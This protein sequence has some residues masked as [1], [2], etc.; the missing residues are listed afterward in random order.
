M[1][2]N[3]NQ[4]RLAGVNQPSKTE[5]YLWIPSWT[6]VRA[7]QKTVVGEKF[8]FP[9]TAGKN[10]LWVTMLS[11][12]CSHQQDAF[13][14]GQSREEGI[15][16]MSSRGYECSKSK[17]DITH[18]AGLYGVSWHTVLTKRSS[19]CEAESLILGI[20]WSTGYHPFPSAYQTWSYNPY[21]LFPSAYQTWS[22][23]FR[24]RLVSQDDWAASSAVIKPPNKMEEGNLWA[25]H[26]HPSHWQ[27]FPFPQQSWG[28]S[29]V[30]PS[31]PH[32]SPSLSVFQAA[33][34]FSLVRHEQLPMNRDCFF[35]N[36]MS[37]NCFFINT[38]YP[39]I[40]C[41]FPQTVC[42]LKCLL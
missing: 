32:T 24:N 30:A 35:I 41:F 25:A 7:V 28:V 19:E 18:A 12:L 16:G 22:S 37:R 36:T 6:H 21:N 9:V 1:E 33:E 23:C 26:C 34:L 17:K 2:R 39:E 20:F 3:K 4:C 40:L 31:A 42:L 29:V 8:Q 15:R 38:S 5:E 27:T 10:A 11:C 13:M 14:L